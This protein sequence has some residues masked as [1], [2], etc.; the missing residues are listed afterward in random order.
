MALIIAVAHFDARLMPSIN[1]FSRPAL[2]VETFFVLSGFVIHHRYANDISSGA[3][4]YASYV[5]KR[6]ARLVPLHIFC[7]SL[8]LV[9]YAIGTLSLNLLE[10]DKLSFSGYPALND[11]RNYG[12]GRWYS[13]ITDALLLN[14]IG[15]HQFEVAREFCTAWIR[16][17]SA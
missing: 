8:L 12:D 15:F 7:L 16:A 4:S 1:L 3:L 14:G 9:V 13:L 6:V 2:A 10:H 17:I 5:K 11:G